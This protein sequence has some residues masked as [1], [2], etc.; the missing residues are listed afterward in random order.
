MELQLQ[1]A[2][3]GT[4]TVTMRLSGAGIKV[5]VVASQRETA[6]R[7]SEDRTEL[8]QIIRRA[9]YDAAE[10]TV[11]AAAGTGGG[12]GDQS[13]PQGGGSRPGEREQPNPQPREPAGGVPESRS[14]RT[15]HV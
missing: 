2:A 13:S 11:E 15:I 14:R 4:L 12:T 9:G 6:T 3:L 5:S 10:I 8:T 1:P 7:L